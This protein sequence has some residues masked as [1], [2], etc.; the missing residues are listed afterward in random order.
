MYDWKHVQQFVLNYTFYAYSC[1]VPLLMVQITKAWR[2]YSPSFSGHSCDH[3]TGWG[4][5][6]QLSLKIITPIRYRKTFVSWLV[7]NTFHKQQ[8]K[9]N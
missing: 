5:L 1:R 6:L 7:D 8:M 2:R 4:A 9:T 3:S